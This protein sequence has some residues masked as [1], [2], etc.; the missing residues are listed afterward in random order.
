VV[1]ALAK[2]YERKAPGTRVHFLLPP[3]GSSAAMRAVMAGAIDLAFTG[4]PLEPAEREKGGVDFALG[5]TPFVL[6]AREAGRLDNVDASRL[7]R[8]Y[9]GEITTWSDGSPIRLILRPPRESDTRTLRGLSPAM[10]KA[11]DLALARKGL[12]IAAN[13]LENLG[14]LENTPGAFGAT[15]LALLIG[16]G[17]ALRPLP[18]D[19][20]APTLANLEK[21]LYTLVKPL[22]A[23]RGPA[24]S[25]A[26]R[27]FLEFASSEEGRA[28]LA[29]QGYASPRSGR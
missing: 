26:A 18:L 23:V 7:A 25:A 3:M 29:R 20:V 22:Y 5:R 27:A 24:P 1:E 28:I 6:A 14:L 4:T 10:D 13:D 12:P 17:S 19:G 21:G 16:T 11:M 9:A 8:I 15:N 2:A